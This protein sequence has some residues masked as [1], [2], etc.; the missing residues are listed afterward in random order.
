MFRQRVETVNYKDFMRRQHDIKVK[1]ETKLYSLITVSPWAMFDPTVLAVA[2]G[3]LAIVLLEKFLVGSS[4]FHLGEYLSEA[5]AFI[6][7]MIFFVALVYFIM[8]N[9]FM[10]WG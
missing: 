2:G 8:T 3:F 9:P 7:P 10:M 1:K 6:C 4:L 5:I